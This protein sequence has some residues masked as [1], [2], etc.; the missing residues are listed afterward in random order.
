[1]KLCEADFRHRLIN[2]NDNPVDKWN[3][4]NCGI[5]VDNVGQCMAVKMESQRR[6]DGG[7]CLIIL[8]EMYRRYRTEL[9]T[10]MERG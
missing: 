5:E 10:I 2:Y 9:N 6:I 8:Y 7:V 3:Y 1:M 4:G